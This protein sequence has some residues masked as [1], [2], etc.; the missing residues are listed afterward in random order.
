ME[1]LYIQA[2]EALLQSAYGRF[3]IVSD[4]IP[5]ELLLNGKPRR[6]K[7]WLVKYLN[8]DESTINANT[9]RS[10][11]H[12]YRKSAFKISQSAEKDCWQTFEPS[13]FKPEQNADKI[14]IKKVNSHEIH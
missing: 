3:D 8:L 12:R 9:L 5:Q 10:W 6:V 4:I 7:E 14:L 2:R 1:T 13:V 11:L